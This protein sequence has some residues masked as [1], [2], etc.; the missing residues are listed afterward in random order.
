MLPASKSD[1]QGLTTI[2][3]PLVAWSADRRQVYVN[4]P[5]GTGA[6]LVDVEAGRAVKSLAPWVEDPEAANPV[7]DV[8]R[9][10]IFYTPID[11][12]LER[13]DLASAA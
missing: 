11:G 4:A 3:W 12:S 7:A 9:Q 2:T 5:D 13:R 10:A 8:E 6:A 1:S